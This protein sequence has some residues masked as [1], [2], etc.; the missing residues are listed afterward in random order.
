[1]LY[2]QIIMLNYSYY[3]QHE[4]FGMAW[5]HILLSGWNA[6]SV[7]MSSC[8]CVH[9]IYLQP[10]RICFLLHFT[11]FHQI[12]IK[13][14]NLLDQTHISNFPNMVHI[15][16]CVWIYQI[17]PKMSKIKRWGFFFNTL[18]IKSNAFYSFTGLEQVKYFLIIISR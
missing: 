15:Q 6:S 9:V 16:K 11:L 8:R 5:Y 10:S 14:C 13:F 4:I 12:L 17:W 2:F 3:I 7:K 1:M 18:Y